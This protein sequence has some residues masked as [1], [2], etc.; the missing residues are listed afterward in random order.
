MRRH[1]MQKRGKGR[2]GFA[3]R[4]FMLLNLLAAALLC[5]SYLA[6]WI[7]PKLFWPMALIGIAYLPLLAVNALF[8]LGWLLTRPP[9]ALISLT[10]ILI[11]WNTLHTH[12]GF[13]LPTNTGQPQPKH[14]ADLRV[15][16]YNVHLFRGPSPSDNVPQVK[17]EALELIREIAPDIICFQEY[18]SREKGALDISHAF[19]HQLGL[20]H[21]HVHA[22]AKNNFESYGMAIFS[23][24]PIVGS[25]RVSDFEQGV[26]SII[27]VDINK[28]DRVFRVYNVHLRSFGFQ[29][30]DYDFIK[31]PTGSLESNVS[32]TRRIGARMKYAFSIRSQQARSLRAHSQQTEIPYLIAGD[33]NDTPLSFAVNHVGRG[34][35]NAFREKGQGWGIT[36]NGDFPNFQI[37]YLLA[38]PGFEIR[39]FEIVRKKLSDHYPIWADLTFR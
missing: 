39:Q 17:E 16:S 5:S 1:K 32:S 26:N 21:Q 9:L 3:G 38:S 24:Y 14:I 7:D 6:P 20:V 25:G 19:K 10:I 4:V 30:E 35:Q 37:D 33:F 15:L 22:V 31:S 13:R 28:D 11:G 34:L 27:Y 18:Y 8:V 36:Y 23:K 2:L 29:K 12:I